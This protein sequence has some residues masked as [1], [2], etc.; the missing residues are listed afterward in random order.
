MACIRFSSLGSERKVKTHEVAAGPL[1]QTATRSMPGQFCGEFLMPRESRPAVHEWVV[2]IAH[3]NYIGVSQIAG[4]KTRDGLPRNP[5]QLIPHQEKQFWRIGVMSLEGA[6]IP[7]HP[8][9]PG[10]KR[11]C[12]IGW[13]P[14][15]QKNVVRGALEHAGHIKPTEI[16][17]P[18]SSG[19]IERAVPLR[20]EEHTSELQSQFHLVC[21]LLLEKKKYTTINTSRTRLP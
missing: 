2:A 14:V 17:T 11:A 6:C 8:L 1:I 19:S 7:Q 16:E 15:G 4:R 12:I 13:Y 10:W 3:C 9:R 21:R 18:V 5:S 20:S